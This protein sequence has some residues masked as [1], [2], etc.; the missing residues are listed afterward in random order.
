MSIR[1]EDRHGLGNLK[2]DSPKPLDRL[3]IP[4][5]LIYF[6]VFGGLLYMATKFIDQEDLKIDSLKKRNLLLA[7]K[8]TQDKL[9]YGENEITPAE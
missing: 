9:L 1:N 2:V 3:K 8:K 7:S 5:F 6:L 4:P